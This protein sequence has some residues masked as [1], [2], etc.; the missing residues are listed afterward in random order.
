M[1]VAVEHADISDGD[2]VDALLSRIDTDLP[3][4]AGV[5]HAAGVLADGVLANQSRERLERVLAPKVLGAWH[6]HRATGDLDLDLF[7][8]FSA[9]AGVLGS[10]GQASYTA[11]NAFLDRLAHH[12]RSLGL[13]GQAVAWGAWS[14]AGM[15]ESRRDRM[16][17]RMRALGQ[18]PLSP[19]Q[20][21]RGPRWSRRARRA[22]GGRGRHGLAG[23]GARCG[24]C[25]AVPRR[26]AAGGPGGPPA[27]RGA[28]PGGPRGPAAQDARGGAR[29]GARGLAPGR[30]AGDPRPVGAAGPDGGVLR[31]GD[32]FADGGGASQPP[33]RRVVG[34]LHGAAHRGVRPSRRPGAWP[35]TCWP[36]R[37]CRR[38]R[39]R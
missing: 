37:E 15:A 8:L 3:P 38:R 27:R 31:P 26:G 39:R 22:G 25:S 34:G 24:Q 10:A 21:L 4:L 30:A 23:A 19:A 11:A 36:R 5:I 7:V 16:A 33:R 29:G 1:T 2:A 18:T 13:A 17:A 6:L 12:R 9:M 14:G 28:G 32:G 20:G 35:V